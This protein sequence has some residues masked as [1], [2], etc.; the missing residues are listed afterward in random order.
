LDGNIGIGIHCGSFSFAEIPH[1]FSYIVG[2]TGT[3]Q[4][5]SDAEKKIV[6]DDYKVKVFTFMPSVFGSNKR[7]FAKEADVYVENKDDYYK[8][9]AE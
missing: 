5:L 2:V 8:I 1:S 3:L 9:I 6:S 4:T 7:K